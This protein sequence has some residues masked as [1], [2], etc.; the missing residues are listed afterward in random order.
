MDATHINKKSR[1]KVLSKLDLTKVDRINF[2]YIMIELEVA[3]KRNNLR[4]GRQRVP[5]EAIKNMYKTLEEPEY[6]EGFDFL[7]IV[8]NNKDEERLNN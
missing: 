5:E 6:E 4:E 3:L 7:Y 1:N 8:D 2:I